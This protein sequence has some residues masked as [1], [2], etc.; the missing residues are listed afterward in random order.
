[1]FKY[2]GNNVDVI[3]AVEYAN[4]LIMSNDFLSKIAAKKQFDMSEAKGRDVVSYIE[5]FFTGMFGRLHVN[6][7]TSK[8][9]WSKAYGYFNP[10][11]PNQ[12][13]LNS[14]KLNRSHASIT[15]SLI[16]ELIHFLDTKTGFYF[17]HG[18]NSPVG[19]ENTIPYWVDNL[20]E[21]MIKG[22][23]SKT[24]SFAYNIV[25]PWYYRLLNT[26]KRWF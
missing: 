2:D 10:N 21:E 15:A 5:Y 6:V 18:N 4:D 11:K 22:D 20:A 9:P 13:Y 1:M 25:T 12:I 17:G 24:G 8:N 7:Y 26:I 23:E 3:C 16:H 19:K 14:R